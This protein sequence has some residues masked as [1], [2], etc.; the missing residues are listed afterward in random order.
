M[1]AVAKDDDDDYDLEDDDNDL[2][3]AESSAELAKQRKLLASVAQQVSSQQQHVQGIDFD[4]M[5]DHD[6]IM[7]QIY[8]ENLLFKQG[9][10]GALDP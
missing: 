7:R 5:E 2:L 9:K 4:E 10:N 1:A 8:Q 6:E 3:D